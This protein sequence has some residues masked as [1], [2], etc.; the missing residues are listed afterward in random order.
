MNTYDMDERIST[1]AVTLD[2]M[3]NCTT[4][5]VYHEYRPYIYWWDPTYFG[6]SQ[7]YSY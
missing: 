6:P 2:K 4:N 5:E 1:V 7:R 3:L